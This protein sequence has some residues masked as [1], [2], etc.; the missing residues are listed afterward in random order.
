ME[1]MQ[2]KEILILSPH[3]V[4]TI[5]RNFNNFNEHTQLIKI[6]LFLLKSPPKP[7]SSPHPKQVVPRNDDETQRIMSRFG[8]DN[9]Q[10]H[11]H[12]FTTRERQGPHIHSNIGESK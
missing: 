12:T 10:S 3:P 4:A 11:M 2:K 6:G 7:P 9:T 5:R 1:K 8:V